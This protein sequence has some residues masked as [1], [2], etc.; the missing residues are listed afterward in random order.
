TRGA[1]FAGVRMGS[2]R[3]RLPATLRILCHPA[4]ME[5]YLQCCGVLIKSFKGFAE[6]TTQRVRAAA[7]KAAECA[8]RPVRFL[9]DPRQSKE[10]LARQIAREDG[11]DS[12]LIAVF[13]EIGRAHV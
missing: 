11:I 7:W 4:I 5:V 3:M 6:A 8:G 10:D 13:S 1:T 12:G 2:E 9:S